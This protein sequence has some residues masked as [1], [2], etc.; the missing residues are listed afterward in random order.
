MELVEEK[1]GPR[2]GYLLHALLEEV[3][4]DPKKNTE[5]YLK[6]RVIELAKLP[7][8]TLKE[9]GEEGKRRRDKFEEEAVKSIRKKY[10][11]S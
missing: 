1:P 5:K 4:D 11:V 2:I 8:E 9:H 6:E 7:E 3:L 10:W